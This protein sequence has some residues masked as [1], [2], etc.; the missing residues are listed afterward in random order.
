MK[1]ILLISFIFSISAFTENRF[2]TTA[3]AV[4]GAK[5]FLPVPPEEMVD[6]LWK[7]YQGKFQDT[8]KVS[9]PPGAKYSSVEMVPDYGVYDRQKWTKY[10]KD[11]DR[12][13]REVNVSGGRLFRKKTGQALRSPRD[14]QGNKMFF[15][16]VMDQ[17]G[18]LYLQDHSKDQYVGKFHHSSFLGGKSVSM[19]GTLF[20]TD[21][22]RVEA[23]TAQSGHYRPPKGLVDNLFDELLEKGVNYPFW[24]MDY[25]GAV[26]YDAVQPRIEGN[27]WWLCCKKK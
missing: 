3:T 21:D 23:I 17:M 12:A 4:K 5:Q 26:K 6:P 11:D 10:F 27:P 16:F 25:G 15:V 20:L 2:K 1:I 7:K 22:G 14:P 8:R 9:K 18:R 13:E 19:A 24:V